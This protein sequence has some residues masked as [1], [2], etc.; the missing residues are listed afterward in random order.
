MDCP[1]NCKIHCFLLGANIDVW[2][3]NQ[4][5]HL[6]SS[7]W[8]PPRWDQWPH[9]LLTTAPLFSFCFFCLANMFVRHRNR[10][11]PNKSFINGLLYSPQTYF[12]FL[13]L[14]DFLR[15]QKKSHAAHGFDQ[16]TSTTTASRNITIQY[17]ISILVSKMLVPFM[18]STD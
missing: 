12:F 16:D 2:W 10:T 11:T 8:V 18:K 4:F 14:S 7:M 1:T 15:I 5:I 13:N 17:L 3:F 6:L 9:L